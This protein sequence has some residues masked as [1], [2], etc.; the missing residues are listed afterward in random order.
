MCKEMG[1]PCS[2][3]YSMLESLGDPVQIQDWAIAG[4]PVDDFSQDSA[5]ISHNA[6]RWPLFIDPQGQANNW[7]KNAYKEKNLL[8]LKMSSPKYTDALQRAIS[9]GLPAL[10][11]DVGEELDPALSAFIKFKDRFSLTDNIIF[12]LA[13]LE[14]NIL[15]WW[16][17]EHQSW[18]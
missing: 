12:R 10:I 6:G 4:L 15:T 8:V 14:A 3:S 18:Q 9:S 2:D 16:N 17:D 7:I 5:I 1:I 11:E 13:L